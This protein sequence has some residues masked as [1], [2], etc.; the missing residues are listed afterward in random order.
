MNITRGESKKKWLC[1]AVTESAAESGH[2]RIHFV[3]EQ[4][5]VA[6]HHQSGG[7]V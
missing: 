5:E 2:H 4:H 1:N 7:A 3:L 6:H